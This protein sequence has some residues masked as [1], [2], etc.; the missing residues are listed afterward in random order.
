MVQPQFGDGLDGVVASEQVGEGALLRDIL[1][2]EVVLGA[3]DHDVERRAQRDFLHVGRLDPDGKGVT[4]AQ[5]D[6]SAQPLLPLGE[7]E[8]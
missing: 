5:L 4:V 8:E 3:V 2:R 1:D 7:R 6:L